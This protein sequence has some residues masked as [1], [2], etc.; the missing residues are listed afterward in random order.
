MK[1]RDKIWLCVMIIL[2][3]LN[4]ILHCTNCKDFSLFGIHI[5][6]IASVLSA[7]TLGLMVGDMSISKDKE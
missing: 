2:M 7:F 5:N 3:V 6:Y 1:K 4:I